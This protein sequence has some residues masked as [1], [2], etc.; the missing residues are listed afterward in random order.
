LVAREKKNILFILPLW[1]EKQRVTVVHFFWQLYF[2]QTVNT[3]TDLEYKYALHAVGSICEFL[4][5]FSN[6]GTSLLFNFVAVIQHLWTGRINQIICPELRL[7]NLT[8][9]SSCSPNR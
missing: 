7:Y 6:L 2:S 5:L 8:V 3:C 1:K 4:L 9:L